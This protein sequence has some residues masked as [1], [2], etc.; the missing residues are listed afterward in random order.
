MLLIS[1]AIRKI[2]GKTIPQ[3][4]HYLPKGA[5]PLL[6][7]KPQP[8]TVRKVVYFPSCINRTM[9]L[10]Q[11][12][13]TK[14]QLSHTLLNLLNKAGYEVIYPQNVSNLCC[15]MPFSSKGY[16]EVGATKSSELER[17]LYEASNQGEIP[18]I[19]DMS[20]CLLTMKENNILGLAL[21]ETVAFIDDFLL[22]YLTITPIKEDITIFPV[23]SV[24]KMGLTDKLESVAKKCA[25]NVI[26]P[27]V[28]CCGFS[29][30]RG[31]DFP[32]LN[33][34]GLKKLKETIPAD[35][36]RAYC[37]SRTCEIGLSLHTD[38]SYQSIVY[39]VDE[40]SEPK[41]LI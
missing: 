9:G 2:S 32:E 3:W 29:G 8:N 19:T 13:Q 14:I 6:E 37:T 30:D 4:N 15:G 40:V 20:P 21:Y 1:T 22:P 39:L 27:E 31:F 16:K 10:S 26:V 35:V 17:A 12:D 36:K 11:D 7:S 38:L 18:I 34:F 41:A 33:Q 5:K 24:K 23:C 25:A 28:T